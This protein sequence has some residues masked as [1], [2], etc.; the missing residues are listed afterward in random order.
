LPWATAGTKAVTAFSGKEIFN[1]ACLLF[2]AIA[3]YEVFDA[4]GKKGFKPVH[5]AGYIACV[6]VFLGAIEYWDRRVWGWLRSIILFVDIRFLLYLSLLLMFIFLITGVNKHTVADLAVTILGTFYICF[7]FWYLIMTRN[8][9][10]GEYAVL[11]VL[12]AAVSTDT[13][14]F[15]VGTYFGKHKLIPEVSPNKTVEGAIGGALSCVLVVTLYGMLVYNKI[16]TQNPIWQY[17]VMGAT[18]GIIAQIGDLA[19]SCL[20][21]YCGIKD[22]GKIIP[23]HGGILDRMDSAILLSPLIHMLLTVME[24]V[25]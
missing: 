16:S 9:R 6:C 23:G 21:R 11:F 1:V 17:I 12:L 22:F 4:F 20:K 8:L 3:V 5:A 24:K 15:F 2:A 10:A 7:L 13:G 18:C 14:A 25:P 19:A